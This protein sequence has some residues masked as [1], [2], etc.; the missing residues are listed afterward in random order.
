M[1]AG[2]IAAGQGERLRSGGLLLPKP[3]ILVAGRALID[4]GL[5]AAAAAGVEQIACIVNEQSQGIEAHCRQQW[6]HL[7]FEFIRRTTPS[8]M[9]SLFAL[10][11]LLRAGPFLLLTTDAV[12]APAAL[13]SFLTAARAHA[14]AQG[15]LALSAFIDDEKPLWARVAGNG[16]IAALGTDARGSG[17][18][19][20]GLYTFDPAIFD[21]MAAARAGGFTALR[22]FL[23]HLLARGY[24]LYGERIAKTVD[25]DRPGDVAVAEAFVRAGF[26]E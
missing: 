16:R 17:L 10:A 5:S 14:D 6:P 11:P 21:E 7:Q 20:A 18:V 2:L 22:Q 26:E 24:R 9:E 19:T 13:S 3:L 12:F 8:S 4:Y 1:K 25:V 15:V 23:G